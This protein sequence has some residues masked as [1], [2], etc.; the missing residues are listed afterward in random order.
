MF[1][2]TD[3]YRSLSFSPISKEVSSTKISSRFVLPMFKLYDRMT[4]LTK[5]VLHYKQLMETIVMSN[6]EKDIVMCKAFASNLSN[7]V[8]VWVS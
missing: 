1:S 5:H 3:V 6:F 7:L 8:L 4:N 2:L